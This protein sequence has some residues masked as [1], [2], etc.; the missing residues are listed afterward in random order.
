MK[1]CFVVA[2]VGLFCASTAFAG[3]RLTAAKT[4][5]P[6][7]SANK[8]SLTSGNALSATARPVMNV[9]KTAAKAR[10][11][12][13]QPVNYVTVGDRDPNNPCTLYAAGANSSY[14]FPQT[15]A[16]VTAAVDDV[17]AVNTCLNDN[18]CLIR[19]TYFIAGGGTNTTNMSISFWR[20]DGT[21]PD[22]STNVPTGPVFTL[23][24]LPGGFTTINATFPTPLP[25][26]G[27]LPLW[28]GFG[29]SNAGAGMIICGTAPTVGSSTRI[30]FYS[31]EPPPCGFGTFGSTGTTRDDFQFT[32]IGEGFPVL[33]WVLDRLPVGCKG[34]PYS[35]G[36]GLAGGLPPYSVT[37]NGTLPAGLSVNSSTGDLSGTPTECG[38]WK[39]DLVAVDSDSPA[40]TITCP[41]KLGIECVTV[42]DL[43]PNESPTGSGRSSQDFET[44]NDAFDDWVADDF[45]VTED[46]TI[47]S[48]S[49]YYFNN[50]GL[51][52]APQ[53]RLSF[54]NDNA[55]CPTP[56]QPAAPLYQ[57]TPLGT[58]QNVF[59][60][61]NASPVGLD[62]VTIFLP[63]PGL[64]LSPG[65][66]HAGLQAIA[67]FGTHGQYYVGATD[68]NLPLC[69][70]ESCWIN[71]GNGFGAGATSWTPGTAVFGTAADLS[72]RIKKAMAM[73]GGCCPCDVNCD[74]FI[75]GDDIAPFVG[76]LVGGGSGCS[77]CAGDINGDTF[78]DGDDIAPFVAAL[79]GGGCPT[80]VCP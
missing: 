33:R 54:Y 32:L 25:T 12:K 71:P 36:L 16:N 8:A 6:V 31:P 69:M 28:I 50:A 2:L 56:N 42:K 37:V 48:V 14:Y 24:G 15:A 80:G 19:F 45:A 1:K 41:V 55:G 63:D 73:G 61:P 76:L 51:P 10:I 49:F 29:F 57:I 64:P 23:A 79:V 74:G 58:D 39:F 43:F 60:S 52:E 17:R 3:S 30:G 22:C 44:V 47:S 7:L 62:M 26:T 34:V 18:V 5:T 59:V 21:D 46:C 13:D 77:P 4:K 68:P 75:D 27:P 67:P 35:A 20:N 11:P 72:M 70:S 53:W 40:S 9:S 66:Y 78:V 38:I 65:T